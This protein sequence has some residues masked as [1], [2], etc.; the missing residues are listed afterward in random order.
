MLSQPNLYAFTSLKNLITDYQQVTEIAKIRVYENNFPLLDFIA[1]NLR[2]QKAM[3]HKNHR[4]HNK[5][6]TFRFT[7]K[8]P[9]PPTWGEG[10]N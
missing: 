4:K 9:Q 2:L 10:V 1:R 5:V 7:T 6:S 3:C 8:I